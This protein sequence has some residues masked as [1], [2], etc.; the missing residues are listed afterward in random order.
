[1][2]DL[3]VTNVSTTLETIWHNYI[4]Y[5]LFILCLYTDNQPQKTQSKAYVVPQRSWATQD[6]CFSERYD[7][8]LLLLYGLIIICISRET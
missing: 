7:R 1:M 5:Q 8:R 4:S 6:I 3:K 2:K